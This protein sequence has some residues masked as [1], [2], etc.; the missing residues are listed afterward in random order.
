MTSVAISKKIKRDIFKSYNIFTNM[1][2][3]DPFYSVANMK[4]LK[5]SIEQ[6]N[7]GKGVEHELIEID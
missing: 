5:K 7:A 3:E 1:K 6:L 2:I 4:R